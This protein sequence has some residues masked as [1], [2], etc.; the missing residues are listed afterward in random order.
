MSDAVSEAIS[1][2]CT[3]SHSLSV[4]H[5]TTRGKRPMLR[6]KAEI[7]I[8]IYYFL[9]KIKNHLPG[10][11]RVELYTGETNML[12][13]TTWWLSAVRSHINTEGFATLLFQSAFTPNTSTL[14]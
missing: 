12:D 7:I 13:D 2:A 3:S 8:K 9:K 11:Q 6:N 4:A 1:N 10:R 5:R 14:L